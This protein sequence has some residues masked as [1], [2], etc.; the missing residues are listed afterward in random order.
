MRR[1][2]ALTH[3]S[4]RY[5]SA[6]GGFEHFF[7]VQ[8]SEPAIAAMGGNFTQSVDREVMTYSATVLKDDVPKAMAVLADAVKVRCG[9]NGFLW[10]RILGRYTSLAV[11]ALRFV[12]PLASF[13]FCFSSPRGGGGVSD[14]GR[15]HSRSLS[16]IVF[17]FGSPRMKLLRSVPLL[18]PLVFRDLG[19][20]R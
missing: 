9:A 2:R 7:A 10:R 4:C 3:L 18:P 11:F 15:G 8:G 19:L 16:T 14:G 13:L 5:C 20:S 6:F 1:L 17:A 12:S